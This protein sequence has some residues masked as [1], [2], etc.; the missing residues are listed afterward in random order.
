[1]SPPLLRLLS[2]LCLL[3]GISGTLSAQMMAGTQ[4]RSGAE[5]YGVCA[6]CHMKDGQGLP[7]VFPALVG[8]DRTLARPEQSIAIVLRGIHGTRRTDG[9]PYGSPMMGWADAFSDEDVARVLTYVRSSWG[10][11]ASAVS[12]TEVARVRSATAKQ[13]GPMSPATLDALYPK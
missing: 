6:A 9:V 4:L 12:A 2:V 11:A 5:L 1:M 8:S 7:G 3:C 10:N 13:T